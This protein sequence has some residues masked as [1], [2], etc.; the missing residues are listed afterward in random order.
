MEMTVTFPGGKR[1]S[2]D[3]NGFTI[4]TDQ[5]LESGGEGTA[6]SPFDYFLAS[7]GT[8]AGYYVL[9]FCQQRGIPTDK[10]SLSQRMEFES[11]PDGKRHLKTVAIDITVPPD[12]PEKYRN[13]LA[14]SAEL[15][16][17]KKAIANPPEF[18]LRTTVAG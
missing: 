5:P 9:A 17:V 1:V 13:A 14:K 18:Q 16:A 8:C 7:I 15:C 2:A 3:F 10:V 11:L 6:P 4:A 12:F